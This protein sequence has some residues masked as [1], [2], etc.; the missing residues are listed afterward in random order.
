[1]SEIYLFKLSTGEEVIGS[2]ADEIV[3]YIDPTGELIQHRLYRESC[4]R[5]DENV[6]VKDL[7]IIK[8]VD[9]KPL[10]KFDLESTVFDHED[11]NVISNRPN[12]ESA[13]A[14]KI[15]KKITEKG[16]VRLVKIAAGANI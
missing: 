12:N 3:N 14:I 1:M 9:I 11:G 13:K 10:Y 16:V 5:T 7:R 4:V 6:Y 2:V 8:N 15:A